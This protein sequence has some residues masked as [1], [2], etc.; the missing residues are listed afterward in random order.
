MAKAEKCI[1]FGG[2]GF[3]GRHLTES[4][5]ASGHEVSVFAR[6]KS[7]NSIPQV[8]YI[9]G[10][11]MNA[12]EVDAA[13]EGHDYVFHLVSLTNPA[14]SDKDPFIDIDTNLKMTVHLLESCVK[15][16][17]KRVIYTSSGGSIYGDA[18]GEVHKETDCIS[19]VSPYAIG[20]AAIEGYLR[21]FH[22]KHNLDYMALRISNVYGEG[23][24]IS[25]GNHGVIPVFIS[26]ILNNEEVKIFGDGSMMRDYIYVKDL[27]NIVSRTF[28]RNHTERLYN[29][30]SGVG[31][32]IKEIL[33]TVEG[34][35][36]MQAR[37]EY[38][39]APASF[40]DR[41]VLDCD[42]ITSEFGK[43]VT[44]TLS[45]GVRNVIDNDFKVK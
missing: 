18:H 10:D 31:V 42:R 45:Q 27:A 37:L 11:F 25:K 23:Q 14:V 34:E 39:D 7:A 3:I 26:R 9:Y 36:G 24:D 6:T 43:A 12:S 1:V 8:N 21:Y 20:K 5:L 44:T 41:V 30:G 38:V 28:N 2:S 17:V 29:V 40:V 4:L 19:P 35:L 22:V 33:D 15:H 13:I 32:T 16:N